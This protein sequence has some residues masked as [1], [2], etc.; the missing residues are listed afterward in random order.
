MTPTP[1][2]GLSAAETIVHTG[3][4]KLD[5][6][7]YLEERCGGGLEG[8]LEYASTPFVPETAQ[9]VRTAFERALNEAVAFGRRPLSE[10]QARL[11]EAPDDRVKGVGE[12]G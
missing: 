1:F 2:T 6:T 7:C 11:E 4:A 5:L 12:H 8:H 10:L 3:T 9:R